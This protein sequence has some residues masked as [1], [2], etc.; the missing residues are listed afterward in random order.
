MVRRIFFFIGVR[1]IRTRVSTEK[2]LLDPNRELE[3]A[4][5]I[6]GNN[7]NICQ[8]LDVW[9]LDNNLPKLIIIIVGSWF[10]ASLLIWSSGPV[11]SMLVG[12]RAPHSPF[13]LKSSRALFLEVQINKTKRTLSHSKKKPHLASRD[14]GFIS[15]LSE[16]KPCK[17]EK[18]KE[19]I[20]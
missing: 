18:K 1:M 19:K 16:S 2:K 9:N 13:T 15:P 17:R 4:F 11:Q 3:I 7:R 20:K 12:F 10:W 8:N 6:R 5:D 14:F